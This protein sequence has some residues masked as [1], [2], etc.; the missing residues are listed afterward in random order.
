MC[1]ELPLPYYRVAGEVIMMLRVTDCCGFKSVF[2]IKG[3][4]L[5]Y[6]H[7]V[8]TMCE[9]LPLPYYRVAGEVI[10]MLR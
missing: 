8:I 7:E 10:M 3:R 6:M 9:E 5:L 2:S 1:E 4:T